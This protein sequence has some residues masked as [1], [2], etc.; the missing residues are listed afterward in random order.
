MGHLIA[1]SKARELS[2][3]NVHQHISIYKKK[4]FYA[5]CKIELFYVVVGCCITVCP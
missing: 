4:I 2:H 3:F 5:H 1:E